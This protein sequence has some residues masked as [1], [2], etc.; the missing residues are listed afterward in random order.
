MTGS[1]LE[2]GVNG[3]SVLGVQELQRS[4]GSAIAE[5][6]TARLKFCEV[7]VSICMFM[8]QMFLTVGL[9]DT[10]LGEWFLYDCRVLQSNE[11]GDGYWEVMYKRAS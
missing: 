5:D 9:L 7:Q 4:Q 8:R 2:C 11:A 3:Q 1:M 6:C 10:E